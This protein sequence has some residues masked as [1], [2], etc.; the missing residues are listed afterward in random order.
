MIEMVAIIIVILL[1]WYLLAPSEYF[2]T[3]RNHDFGANAVYSKAAG[4][5]L[6]VANTS[7]LARYDWSTRD[8]KGFTVYDK[9]Y[10]KLNAGN[11]I[12]MEYAYKEIESEDGVYD[13]KF[14][15]LEAASTLG[16]YKIADMWDR[17]P[18]LAYDFH[19]GEYSVI[20][21]KNY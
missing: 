21:Q 19:S 7:E 14:D 6:T 1:C 4:K 10:D 20:S 15:N 8:P 9:Y 11:S 2:D 18:A 5:E 13:T 12:D 17:N 16:Q 3:Y